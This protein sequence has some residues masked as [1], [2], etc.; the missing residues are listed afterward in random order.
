MLQD[1]LADFVRSTSPIDQL[2]D[3]RRTPSPDISELCQ[4][5]YPSCCFSKLRHVPVVFAIWV[6]AIC[7]N[8][9]W[10]L[11]FAL[12]SRQRGGYEHSVVCGLWLL[13]GRGVSCR[14]LSF[15]QSVSAARAD[16][17]RRCDWH[18]SFALCFFRSL[19]QRRGCRSG[20]RGIYVRSQRGHPLDSQG[21]HSNLLISFYFL[22]VAN[23][24][25]F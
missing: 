9:S 24:F 12:C 23:W 16:C 20:G 15:R 22:L 17:R 4:L 6:L 5:S 2:M 3:M 11:C 25:S 1:I 19:S 10:E 8:C 14:L 21:V 13:L 7:V 18:F